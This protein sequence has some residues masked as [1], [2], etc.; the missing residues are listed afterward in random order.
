MNR[1]LGLFENQISSLEERQGHL[2]ELEESVVVFEGDL[3]GALSQE[4]VPK[5]MGE[6]GDG[7]EK[8]WGER[9]GG[10]DGG[11]WDGGKDGKGWGDGGGGEGKDGGA[12]EW[13]IACGSSS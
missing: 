11:E 1:P 4:L 10:R 12:D 3:F 6:E 13:W 5:G 9:M 7:G 2:E 8:G